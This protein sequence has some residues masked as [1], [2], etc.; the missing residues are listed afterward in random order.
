MS[1]KLADLGERVTGVVI[2]AGHWDHASS[3]RITR[4]AR[5]ASGAVH[6]I[7]PHAPHV[8]GIRTVTGEDLHVS[9]G[10]RR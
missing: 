9:L 7:Y 2:D 8:V 5:V 6:V 3:V 10:G 1:A 4:P